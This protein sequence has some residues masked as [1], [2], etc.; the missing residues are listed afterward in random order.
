M[1]RPLL[2]LLPV[3]SDVYMVEMVDTVNYTFNKSSV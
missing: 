2:S 3:T 1:E